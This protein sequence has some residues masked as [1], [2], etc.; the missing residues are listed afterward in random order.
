MAAF[1]IMHEGH[2][3]IDSKG[4]G[5]ITMSSLWKTQ[6]QAEEA[7]ARTFPTH[8]GNYEPKREWIVEIADQDYNPTHLT[9]LGT[10][11]PEWL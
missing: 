11:A 6:E 9:H 2:V 10:T 1:A 3:V 4:N 8:F 7:V 5:I